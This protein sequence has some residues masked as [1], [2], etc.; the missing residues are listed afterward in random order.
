MA[1]IIIILIVIVLVAL[2]VREA[3]KHFS[4][5][6][7]CCGGGGYKAKKKKLAK[8][9]AKKTFKVDGMH[10]ENC[11]NRV[12][13]V[14]NDIHGVAGSVNLKSGIL[15]VSYAEEVADDII[16]K[17]IERVGYTVTALE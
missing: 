8:V 15:T 13:E 10:C 5:K 11:S 2:G 6:G 7:G 17:K 1:N 9:I 4:G 14:V 16:I 3:M 12:E